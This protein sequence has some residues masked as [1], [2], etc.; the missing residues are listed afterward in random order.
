VADL[1]LAADQVGQLV[2]YVAPGFLALLGYRTRFPAPPRPPG[3]TVIIAAAASL[4]LVALVH[5]VLPGAQRPTQLAYVAVLLA[6]S[7]AIGYGAAMARGH[8]WGR[9]LLARADHRIQPEGSIYAQT[10]KH[11]SPAASILVELEDGRRVSGTPRNGPECKDDGI[12]ELYLTHPEALDPAF[13]QWM[14]AGAG[15]IIPLAEVST[16]VLSEDPTGA[17]AGAVPS[18]P[19]LRL[20]ASEP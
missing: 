3:E 10:L 17:P 2:T 11:L 4:P 7:F 19:Q 1:T 15:I 13:G 12:N 18:A 9:R 20:A 8:R 14:P 5:A 16:I 6:V